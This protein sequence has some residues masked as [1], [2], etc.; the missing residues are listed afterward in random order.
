M[1]NN[2]LKK[3]FI[4]NTLGTGLNSFNSLF[5]L[6]ITTRINGANNAGVFTLCFATACMF[7][8]VALYSGRTYQV[9]ETNK[10]I[11]DD[12]YIINRIFS[13]IIMI[14]ISIVFGF[15]NG[16]LNNKLLILILLCIFKSSDA[17]CD[18]FHGILQKNDRLDIVGKSLFLRSILNIVTF[19]IVDLLTNNLILSCISLII[20]NIII[21]LVI[22]INLSLKFKEKKQTIKFKNVFNI[23]KLGF[24]AFGFSF[25]ANYLVNIPRYAIE[26]LNNDSFQTI[27]GIV[28]M[29]ATI[30]MLISHF[31]TQPLIINLKQNYLKKDKQ[32]FLSTI[33]KIFIYISIIGIVC[34]ICCYFL[35][36]PVLNL[37]Y[38]LDLSN[39]LIDLLLIILGATFYTLSSLFSNSM[40]I[41]RK[42]KIQFVIFVLVTII[43]Y[44]LC[45]ILVNTI[46][47]NG[48]A[49]G[50]L[51]SMLVLLILYIIYFIYLIKKVFE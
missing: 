3:S 35:G 2:N 39:Y 23:F 4:W 19:L 16:Y 34:L 37:L 13:S 31:I 5:F 7:Y 28:V 17:I 48:A 26:C 11:T 12:D 49:I 15:V 38:G 42:T 29:P 10:N 9:T 20:S 6:I 1:S 47:F 32:K 24:Y 8:C 44:I 25:I 21:L 14:L 27:F 22:D 36:V 40:I 30:I 18:V 43:S 50:Y 46:G 33:K 51:L 41:F 45:N